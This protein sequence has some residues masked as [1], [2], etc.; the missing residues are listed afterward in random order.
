MKL[1]E[2]MSVGD[3]NVLGRALNRARKTLT[4]LK[5]NSDK[6]LCSLACGLVQ[7][8]DALEANPNIL[9]TDGYSLMQYLMMLDNPK[10]GIQ[11]L[12]LVSD[13]LGSYDDDSGD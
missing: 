7:T 5:K 1:F 4:K 11:T 9:Q 13:A 8:L 3:D 10:V 12:Q 2:L 6:E